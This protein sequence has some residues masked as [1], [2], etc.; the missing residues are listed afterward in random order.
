M[1]KNHLQKKKTIASFYLQ[2]DLSHGM[3]LKL[4]LR[5][6]H[7]ANL[8]IPTYYKIYLQ[9]TYNFFKSLSTYNVTDA[10]A[11]IVAAKLP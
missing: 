1:H 11:T 9:R 5:K 8:S 6:I 10:K 7:Y 3:S 4:K 2:N